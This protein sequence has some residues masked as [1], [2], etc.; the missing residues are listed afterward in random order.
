MLVHALTAAL[1]MEGGRRLTGEG[2]GNPPLQSGPATILDLRT[3]LPDAPHKNMNAGSDYL[4]SI[5]GNRTRGYVVMKGPHIVA[6]YYKQAN[7]KGDGGA[8]AMG[9]GPDVSDENDVQN[10]YSVTKTFLSTLVG[11]ALTKGLTTL[12]TTLGELFE[13]FL[14][15]WPDGSG[16]KGS[17][18]QVNGNEIV[19][20]MTVRHIISFSGGFMSIPGACTQGD[21]GTAQDTLVN[22]LNWPGVSA[23]LVGDLEYQCNGAANSWTFYA[24]TGQTPIEYARTELFP[25]LGITRHVDWLPEY[26]VEKINE[27]GKGLQ[28]SP[29]EFA[30]LGMLYKQKG[31]PYPGAEP[32][33]SRYFVDQSAAN[34][35]VQP[36]Q[37][38]QPYE[39]GACVNMRPYYAGYSYNQWLYRSPG[40]GM[41]ENFVQCAIGHNGQ[42]ICIFPNTDIMFTTTKNHPF[43]PSVWPHDYRQSCDLVEA[44]LF[45]LNDK[46]LDFDP[47]AGPCA[48]WCTKFSASDP[49]CT[50]CAH[51]EMCDSWCN[52]YT[53]HSSVPFFAR[54]CG[55]CEACAEERRKA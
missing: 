33:I 39:A 32:L 44:V 24:I 4:R 43:P 12:E 53:C 5:V 7:Y 14:G 2:E 55:G 34:Q 26:G 17:W 36:L 54:H 27:G 20:A 23:D 21:S 9:G 1:A 8:M 52:A 50:G 18:S 22:T 45:G 42:Y 49:M 15:T 51:E 30:K 16:S 38:D 19:K 28:L 46:P 40:S 47:P 11:I 29:L 10:I 13:P 48:D 37:D 41:H 3:T 31:I 35:L 6:D 25:H